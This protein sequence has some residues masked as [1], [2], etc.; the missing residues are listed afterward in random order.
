MNQLAMMGLLPTP[1]GSGMPPWHSA[2][3]LLLVVIVMMGVM[4]LAWA[5]GKNRGR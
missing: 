5:L 2:W 3:P 1:S 4:P